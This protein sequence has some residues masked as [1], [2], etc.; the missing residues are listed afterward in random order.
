MT[1]LETQIVIAMASA[2]AGSLLTLYVIAPIVG[3]WAKQRAAR[4]ARHAADK[5]PIGGQHYAEAAAPPELAGWQRVRLAGL[6]RRPVTH[7]GA[8]PAARLITD[9]LRR[10]YPT[11]T[12]LELAGVLLHLYDAGEGIRDGL[13]NSGWPPGVLFHEAIG[14]AALDL[15]DMYRTLT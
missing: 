4:P 2:I 7:P 14:L 3:R 13:S 1:S 11:L 8:G 10:D 5:P 9:L 6:Q 12:D 15:T